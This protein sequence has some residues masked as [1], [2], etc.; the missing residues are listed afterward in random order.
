M[1]TVAR[2]R[3]SRTLVVVAPPDADLAVVDVLA[4]L[5]LALRRE[6]WTLVLRDAE[7]DLRGLIDLA[8]LADVLLLEPRREPERGIQLRV[9]EVV[10]P[11]DSIT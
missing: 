2:D 6:G 4:R 9:E 5:Q 1:V 10:E 8:G 11:D 7:P 3:E